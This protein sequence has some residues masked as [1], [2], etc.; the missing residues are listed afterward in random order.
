MF[1]QITIFLTLISCLV[2]SAC[3]FQN[4]QPVNQDTP[5]DRE[6][7]KNAITEET[8][9]YETDAESSEECS[10]YEDYDAD[11]GVCYFECNNITECDAIAADVDTEIASW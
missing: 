2:L 8:Y 3:G 10:S 9:V 4:P 5:R 6:A 1:K 11:N 7:V